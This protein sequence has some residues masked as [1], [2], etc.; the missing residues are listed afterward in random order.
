MKARIDQVAVVVL[1]ALSLILAALPAAR[2]G[3]ASATM[4]VD[5]AAQ[6]CIAGGGRSGGG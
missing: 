5:S 3:P 1:M 2:S 4:T 6:L